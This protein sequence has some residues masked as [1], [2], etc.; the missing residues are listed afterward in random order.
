MLIRVDLSW[1]CLIA[2]QPPK[3]A[4]KAR[5][6]RADPD[7]EQGKHIHTIEPAKEQRPAPEETADRDVQSQPSSGYHPYRKTSRRGNR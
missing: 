3:A 7:V 1:D 6:S 4:L 5:I 2:T